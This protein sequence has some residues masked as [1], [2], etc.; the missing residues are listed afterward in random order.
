MHFVLH[1]INFID[2]DLLVL[3]LHARTEFHCTTPDKTYDNNWKVNGTMV[4]NNST[5]PGVVGIASR[6]LSNGSTQGSLTFTAYANANNTD[7]L[8]FFADGSDLIRMEY[9]ILIQGMLHV[10]AYTI[11]SSNTTAA[12]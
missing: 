2:V 11:Q 10:Y 8:C 5:F 9:K 6:T 3:R 4:T 1:F 7:V 12:V